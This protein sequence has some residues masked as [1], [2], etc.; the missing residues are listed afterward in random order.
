[1]KHIKSFFIY[2]WIFTQVIVIIYLWSILLYTA[3]TGT[4]I[5]KVIHWEW[6]TF[7]FMLDLWS[8]KFLKELPSKK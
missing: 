4:E 8:A 3:F 6:W 1:M 2:S 5:G 7:L